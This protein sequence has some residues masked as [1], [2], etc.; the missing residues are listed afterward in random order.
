MYMWVREVYNPAQALSGPRA[1]AEEV[2]CRGRM[3]D[4]PGVKGN[5][6]EATLSSALQNFD[7]NINILVEAI[8][9]QSPEGD[10]SG[11]G[12][13]GKQGVGLDQGRCVP[14]ALNA[15]GNTQIRVMRKDV[16]T[17]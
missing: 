4:G 2:S 17:V 3:V 15:S 16:G 5:G 7:G 8:P 11:R 13:I 10:V 12:P 14:S 6:W 9:K 1:R